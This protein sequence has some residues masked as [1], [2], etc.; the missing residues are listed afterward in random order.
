MNILRN[1]SGRGT[2]YPLWLDL[3]GSACKRWPT[4][5]DLPVGKSKK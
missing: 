5:G 1:I 2:S 3:R 4:G